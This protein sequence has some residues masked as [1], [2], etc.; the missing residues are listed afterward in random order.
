MSIPRRIAS[1]V[2]RWSLPLVLTAPAT[3]QMRGR[4]G[5][6]G[7]DQHFLTGEACALCHQ[8]TATAQALWGR[9]GDDVSPFS[10][11]Q[12]TMMANSF[13]D[14]YWRA[15][16]EKE[17]SLAP[18]KRPQIEGLCI[19]CHAPMAHHDALLHRHDAPLITDIAGMAIGRD[20]VSCTVCHQAQADNLGTEASF[21]GNLQITAEHRI[22]GPYKEPG[23]QPMR[24][25]TGY[26][27]E[28][29]PHIRNAGLCGACHT[30]FTS[31]VPGHDLF[32]EQ[33]P[34]LEWRNSVFSDE[35]G[36]TE[37]SRSC[38]ECHMSDEGTMRI[39][40]N[41]AGFDF[42][43]KA[44]PNARAHSFVGGNAFMLD[45]LRTNRE[46]LGVEAS[47]DALERNARATRRQLAHDT[48]TVAV[49]G[50]TREGEALS[51][52]VRVTN[53]TGHKLP[54]GYPARRAWLRV[55]VRSGNKPVFLSGEPD[56]QGR[57]QGVADERALPHVDRVEKP[58]QVV[59]YECIPVDAAGKP[60]TYLTQMAALGKDNRLLPKGWRA[61][62]PEV[63]H[64]APKGLG[65]DADF[66]GGEDVVHYALRLPE[67]TRGRLTLVVSLL[68][69]TVP[70]SWVEPMR[71][72]T[73]DATRQFVTMYDAATK[74][75]ETLAFTA[76][77]VD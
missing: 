49:E 13:R 56:A 28:Y 73:A 31:H 7:P 24:M 30:L 26:Q 2:I 47:P 40:R 44:R 69:Q 3:A 66:V 75:P 48:A 12:A 15:Q 14:P 34:Y 64:T 71:N 27:A 77:I 52:A 57:I 5:I 6:V 43:I 74:K 37:Q 29:G 65:D 22:F 1:L 53:L 17:V 9:N 70:P 32:P 59:V 61:D 20:G 72:V 23:A 58:E 8:A 46:A 18:D 45:M 50:L 25:H 4:G 55:L 68:Y 33:T 10:T 41:P 21:S 54:T 39:A 19:R 38:Q 63:Q 11:W 62:G 76:Q 16:V 35:E 36:R 51:F 67:G 60:T 42:N